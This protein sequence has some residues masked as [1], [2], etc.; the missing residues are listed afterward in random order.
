M[1]VRGRRGGVRT[2]AFFVGRKRQGAWGGRDREEEATHT[3]ARTYTHT[4]L[5]R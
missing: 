5:L 1:G 4:H 2:A 3:R